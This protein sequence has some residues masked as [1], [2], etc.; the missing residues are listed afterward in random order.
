MTPTAEERYEAAFNGAQDEWRRRTIAGDKTTPKLM[1]LFAEM[2][3]A[4]LRL[5]YEDGKRD[6]REAYRAAIADAEQALI[7]AADYF[8]NRADVNDGDYG[9]PSPNR[10]MTLASQ[11]DE[12]LER[13]EALRARA[14]MERGR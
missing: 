7:D 6:E 4:A 14:Q 12:A 10:E 3:I 11:C 9:E 5:A 8:G 1:E 2:M 13:L